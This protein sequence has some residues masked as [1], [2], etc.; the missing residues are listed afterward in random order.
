MNEKLKIL[1]L[2][3]V[4]KP[5]KEATPSCVIMRI[6]KDVGVASSFRVGV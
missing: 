5:E 6:H 2:P 4:T 1:N 3:L